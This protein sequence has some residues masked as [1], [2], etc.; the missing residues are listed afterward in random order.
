[1]CMPSARGCTPLDFDPRACTGPLRC[2]HPVLVSG[3]GSRLLYWQFSVR[4]PTARV[5][6]RIDMDPRACSGTFQCVYPIHLGIRLWTWIHVPVPALFVVFGLCTWV[7]ASGRGSTCLYWPF[8]GCTPGARLWTRLDVVPSACRGSFL[9]V[10]FVHLG[11]R[12][13]T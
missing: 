1:M 7:Y 3:R 10:R 6:T 12:L 11:V 4:K 8:S 9:C 5:C 2:V 13:W